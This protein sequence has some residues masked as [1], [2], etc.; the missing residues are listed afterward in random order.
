MTFTIVAAIGY[1]DKRRPAR[2]AHEFIGNL[3]AEEQD[4]SSNNYWVACDRLRW[5]V[6]EVRVIREQT[7]H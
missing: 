6:T 2:S 5:P 3:P 4:Q 7:E 1:P